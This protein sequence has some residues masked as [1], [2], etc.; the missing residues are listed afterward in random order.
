MK[1][2]VSAVKADKSCKA[3]LIV[4]WPHRN[5]CCGVPAGATIVQNFTIMGNSLGDAPWSGYI[6]ITGVHSNNGTVYNTTA[7]G[8]NN[9]SW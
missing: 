6:P 5:D 7:Y 4:L 8:Y 3:V 1:A 9:G 2:Y